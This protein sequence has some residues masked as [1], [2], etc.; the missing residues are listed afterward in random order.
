MEEAAAVGNLNAVESLLPSLLLSPDNTVPLHERAAPGASTVLDR[1]IRTAAAHGWSDVTRFFIDQGAVIDDALICAVINSGSIEQC[2]LLLMHG[3]DV[4]RS[5]ISASGDWRFCTPLRA[6]L[7][8]IQLCRWL[9]AHGADPNLAEYGFTPIMVAVRYHPPEVVQLLIDYGADPKTPMLL[10]ST[11]SASERAIHEAYPGRDDPDRIRVMK[12]LL[13]NGADV[14]EMEPDPKSRPRDH[15]RRKRTADTG[16]PLHYAVKASNPITVSF[17]LA[18]GANTKL[19][20]WSGHT[21]LQAA[22]F[23]GNRYIAQIL[24]LYG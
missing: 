13:D 6:A 9:L 17:L 3:W 22:E 18:H 11:A 4:N 21:P 1:S 14:N 20:S 19:P 12:I 8:D 10:H 15:D 16:T 23:W 5:Y 2:E 24:R 7:G